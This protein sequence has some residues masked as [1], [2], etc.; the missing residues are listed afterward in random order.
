MTTDAFRSHAAATQAEINVTPLIDVL[1]ALVVILMVTAPL[2]MKRLPLPL[3][4]NHDWA[5]TSRTLGLSVLSTGE[6]YLQGHAVSRAELASALA[7]QAQMPKPPVLEVRT[8]AD[9][10][11]ANVVDAL[12]VAR[13]SGIDGIQIEGVRAK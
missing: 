7:I 1:L 8:D 4:G 13:S 10:P 5:S 6:L 11:Y 2:A 3:G 9:T 12:A